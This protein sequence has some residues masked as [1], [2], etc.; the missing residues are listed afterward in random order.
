M[1]LQKL[2]LRE[3]IEDTLDLL[4]AR[5][6]EKGLE[7]NFRERGTLPPTVFGDPLRLRQVLALPMLLTV[8]WLLWVL[9]QQTGWIGDSAGGFARCCAM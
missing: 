6:H 8:A 5:A 4:A 3:V 9:A 1:L 7:L 2:L